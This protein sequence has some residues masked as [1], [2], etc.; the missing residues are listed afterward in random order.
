MFKLWEIWGWLEC[1]VIYKIISK[2]LTNRLQPIMNT[3]IGSEHSAFTKG[4]LISDNILLCHEVIHYL[5]NR[6][7]SKAYSIVL[8]LDISK[9]YERVE[10]TYLKHMLHYFGFH[11]IWTNWIL[12]CVT[13]VSYSLN[14]NGHK[15]DVIK[16][17]RGLRK[18]DP[19]SPY[20]FLLYV[21]GLS[22]YINQSSLQGISIS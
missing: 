2:I 7:K 6:R 8:K 10:W 12:E 20:L 1:N 17:I 4:H 21:E 19:L 13:T 5:N 14:I 15:L 16:S 9:A 3:I 11:D 22:H 18:G